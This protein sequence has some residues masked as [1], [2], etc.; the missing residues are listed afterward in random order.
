LALG[1]R[2]ERAHD[3]LLVADDD[4]VAALLEDRAQEVALA[5][6]L[7]ARLQLVRDVLE[8]DGHVAHAPVLSVEREERAG[9][10]GPPRVFDLD[11]AELARVVPDGRDVH[12]LAREGAMDELEH[13]LLL[14]DLVLEDVVFG[15]RLGVEDPPER[16]VDQ[17]GPPGGVVHLQA[18]GRMREH[19]LEQGQGIVHFAETRA[20]VVHGRHR[21]Q[22]PK[23]ACPACPAG[24][25]STSCG[26][27]RSSACCG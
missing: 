16:V 13:A 7:V 14:G 22:A 10:R 18:E 5:F 21:R 4:P 26:P 2:V 8:R 19:P 17:H 6:R 15:R 12:G 9:D 23:L 24:S 1:L 11:L 20:H 3:A 25:A 27:P